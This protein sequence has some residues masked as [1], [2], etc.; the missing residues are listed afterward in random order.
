V[1]LALTG[2]FYQLIE[3]RSD[4]QRFHRE[5]KLVDVGGYNLSINCTGQGS[6]VVMLESGLEIPG[7]GWRLV[8]PEVAKFTRVCSY[9]RAGYAW[10][11]PGR[12]PRTLSQIVLEMHSLL[13]NAGEKPPYVLVG[14]SFGKSDVLFYHKLYPNDVVGVVLVDGGPDKLRL[15]ASIWALSLADLKHRQRRRTFAFPLYFFGINR[16][17]A[18]NDIDGSTPNETEY[19]EEWAYDSIQPNFIRATTSEVEN[20]LSGNTEE[21]TGDEGTLGD[22]PLIVLIAGKGMWGLPLMSQDWADLHKTWVDGQEQLAQHLSTRGKWVIVA[23]ST[24]MIPDD[25]PGAIVDAVHE[26]YND[27]IQ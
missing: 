25:K 14:H 13:Q 16:F 8:Q 15:P 5:G 17:L 1:L 20:L 24:H 27:I 23:D 26:I 10:S 9:D 3:A 18:R 21:T 19:D 11:D 12:M 22:K 6:P 7:K 2:I 4:A